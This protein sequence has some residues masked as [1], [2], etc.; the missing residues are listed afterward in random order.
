FYFTDVR[1]FKKS[2]PRDFTTDASGKIVSGNFKRLEGLDAEARKR[3]DSAWSLEGTPDKPVHTFDLVLLARVGMEASRII[4]GR[5]DNALD[6]AKEAYQ[7]EK[8]PDKK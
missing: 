4:D 2:D 3:L 7:A 5:P 6:K 8:D 1:D